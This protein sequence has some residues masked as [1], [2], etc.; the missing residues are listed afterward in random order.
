MFKKLTQ[1][2]EANRETE[3]GIELGDEVRV[4]VGEF[5]GLEGKVVEAI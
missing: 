3:Q 4:N 5:N 2:S 1:L